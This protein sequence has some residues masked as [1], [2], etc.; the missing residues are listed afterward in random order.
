MEKLIDTTEVLEENAVY[1]LTSEEAKLRFAEGLCNKAESRAG[2]SYF[3][4]VCDNLF[5]FF[6]FIWVLVTAVL[7][8]VES[9]TNLTFLI[10]VVPNTLIALY[11][12][13]L[14]SPKSSVE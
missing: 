1:G 13:T 10:V 12:R 4:I 6:N 5:T 9:Y 2:K 14:S 8:A 11:V 7:I 3:K